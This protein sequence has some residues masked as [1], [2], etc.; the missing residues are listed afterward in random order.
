MLT[1]QHPKRKPLSDQRHH[2]SGPPGT[3]SLRPASPL[4]DISVRQPR[5]WYAALAQTTSAGEGN[6]HH[7][8]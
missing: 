4:L 2:T 3:A 5:I 7:E 8:R 1:Q 6:N